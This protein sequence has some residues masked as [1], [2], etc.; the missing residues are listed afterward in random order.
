MITVTQTSGQLAFNATSYSNVLSELPPIQTPVI[1]STKTKQ[2]I[3]FEPQTTESPKQKDPQKLVAR[4]KLST[5]RHESPTSSKPKR[6][7]RKSSKDSTTAA[8]TSKRREV[9]EPTAASLKSE[10]TARGTPRRQASSKQRFNCKLQPNAVIVHS[11]AQQA[12]RM[13]TLLVRSA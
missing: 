10:F 4:K 7:R 1:P 13:S 5:T 9:V 11:R 12:P 3:H 6:K 2:I 8:S